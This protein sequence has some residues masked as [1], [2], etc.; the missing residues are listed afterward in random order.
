MK[1]QMNLDIHNYKWKYARSQR[2]VEVSPISDRNKELIF[3]YR[4]ACILHQV[5]GKVRLIRVME[6]LKMFAHILNKDFDQLTKQDLQ[7]LVST[8]MNRQPPYS[9]ETLGTYKSI[10][11]RFMSYVLSPEQFPN[12][13]RLPDMLT[14][15]KTHVKKKDVTRLQRK[16]LLTPGDIEKLLHVCHNPR[17]K[18]LIAILWETGCRIAEIGNMQIKHVTK[19]KH[20]FT[21]DISGKTGERSPII[22][23]AA[24]YLTQW[25]S[26]HPF[27]DNPE[28]PLWVH[29]QYTKEPKHLKYS[30]IRYL[31][32]RH[33]KHAG[34]TKPFHPHIFRHSRA[35]YV[36]AN[37]IMNESQ[38]KIYFGWAPDSKMLA[39]YSHLIDQDVTN[40][41]LKENNLSPM[42]KRHIELQPRECKIC[43]E[44][45]PPSTEYCV[46][47]GAVLDMTKA[48]EHQRVHEETDALFVNLF[49]VMVDKGLVDEAVQAIH[50]AGMGT[51]LKRL[52]QHLSKEKSITE[53]DNRIR[54]D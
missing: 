50:D 52:A 18:A 16:D 13:E 4:D 17:D 47:C 33:F 48:Y 2:L 30:S 3:K 10:L 15:I 11:K 41:I 1:R 28:A 12:I 25:I 26:M 32:K 31:L 45:N 34:I 14:W 36:L 27:K 37:G 43:H 51:R 20:G 9:A 46:T 29:Y 39:T 5:C 49:K 38:A 23:S 44:L 8:M 53:H 22:I 24:P 19:N 54:T 6:A 35:T 42:Q 40:A 7:Y 21:L